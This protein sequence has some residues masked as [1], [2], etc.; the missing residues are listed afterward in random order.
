MAY[1]EAWLDDNPLTQGLA[2][3]QGKLRAWQATLST[4]AAG[5]YGGQLPE[6]FAA[7]ARFATSPAGAFT[8]LL[9]AA[10]LTGDAREE[11][12]RM[13]EQTGVA[14]DKLS[15]YAYAARRAGISNETLAAAMQKL[16]S[17]EFTE[18]MQGLGG[19]GG[20]HGGKLQYSVALG[21]DKGADAADQLRQIA[22][23]FEGLDSVQR[24]GLARKLGISELLPL[25]NQGAVQLDAFT[26]RAK[27]L[28]LV[29][30]DKDARAGKNFKTALG[31]LHDVLMSSVGAIGGALLPIIT[32]LTKAIVPVAVGIRDWIKDHKTLTIALFAGTGAIVAGGVALKALSIA[33]G[34]AATG[35]GVLKG[36][37]ALASGV[38]T[39]FNG[40]L[41]ATEA[42]MGSA[43]LPFLVVGGAVLGIL[44]YIGELS[45]AF[46]NLG[47]QWQG[48]AS[49][50]SS[51][52][53]AI[54]DA[55]S[56]GNF[57]AA[58][59]VVTAYFKAEWQ[60]AINTF[61]EIWEGYR[62]Y[63][64]DTYFGMLEGWNDFC[65][66]FQTAFNDA[67]GFMQKKWL[68]F[69][70]STFTETAANALAPIMARI[71]NVKTE[72][73][74]RNLSEDF[75]AA[76]ASQGQDETNI[77]AQTRRKNAGVEDARKTEL[78]RLVAASRDAAQARN[79]RLAAAES[80]LNKSR[81]ALRNAQ[82]AAS[83]AQDGLNLPEQKKKAFGAFQAAE[84]R[85]TY[86]GAVAG[87]LGG[88]TGNLINLAQ[89]E[90]DELREQNQWLREMLE[91]QKRTN[92]R[93]QQ[94]GVV[95]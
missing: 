2:K 24:A 15:A 52:I 84:V 70:N 77:D 38:V 33:T 40:V 27:E 30:S 95:L 60:R 25:L 3:L 7:I 68:A 57:Q 63:F 79:D 67:I 75:A 74:R 83:A 28:G 55:I 78:D 69:S 23:Q 39:V 8:A 47:N 42:I 48:F 29:M 17:R 5:A 50:T 41:A 93:L 6:P 16:Q 45:G 12:L 88:G 86:S 36:V 64:T 34:L 26:A 49:D 56:S 89:Q 43:A 32:G 90:I 31:D 82:A 10:K 66:K 91:E 58:W 9:G 4:T 35:I 1:V 81:D 65:A 62:S 19:G 76:R 18:A 92:Q 72:D 87:M 73:V 37:F 14:V 80:Q 22:Q 11:M 59:D 20:K 53:K 44:G 61:Q 13:S 21:L 71:Y 85:G 54:S 94:W 46:A 51:S